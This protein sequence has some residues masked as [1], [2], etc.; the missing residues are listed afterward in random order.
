MKT[1]TLPNSGGTITLSGNINVFELVGAERD[2][3]F[4]L[5]DTMRKFEES[6]GGGSD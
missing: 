4:A 3:V 1:I 5:I 2:L 6:Q